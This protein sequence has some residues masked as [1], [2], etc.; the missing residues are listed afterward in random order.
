M[1]GIVVHDSHYH[2]VIFLPALPSALF[3]LT[4]PSLPGQLRFGGLMGKVPCSVMTALC[5]SNLT[6]ALEQVARLNESHPIAPKFLGF[7][8]FHP[9]LMQPW[10]RPESLALQTLRTEFPGCWK[11]VQ[12]SAELQWFPT[13]WRLNFSLCLLL[14]WGWL[15]SIW[16]ALFTKESETREEFQVALTEANLAW[17]DRDL[18][19]A[20]AAGSAPVWCKP[21]LT[22]TY[23][24]VWG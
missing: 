15:H 5:G 6:G 20:E 22:H 9:F 18:G 2:G 1:E 17:A 13:H 12:E 10:K 23:T 8:F 16:F 11:L 4:T 24:H 7:N 21:H 3:S 14:V 19:C